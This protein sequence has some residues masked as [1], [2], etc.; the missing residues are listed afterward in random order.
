MKRESRFVV[1]QEVY[2]F[3]SINLRVEKDF[4]QAVIIAPVQKE[5]VTQH[6]DKSITERIAGG[7]LE[8]KEQY[9]LL[10]HQGFLGGECLF[11]NEKEL[12][13]FFKGYFN[14]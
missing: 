1:G 10:E 11:E 7:E 4:V 6:N 5:G 3:N 13:E 9:Q 12:K 8:V 2:L 14:K